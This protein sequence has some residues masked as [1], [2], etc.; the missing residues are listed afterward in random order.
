MNIQ[1][2]WGFVLLALWLIAQGMVV[3]FSL[4]FREIDLVLAIV[5]ILAGVF[6]LFGK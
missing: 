3:A 5:A 4:T 6:I 1:R 2:Q